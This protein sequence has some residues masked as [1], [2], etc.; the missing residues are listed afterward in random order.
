MKLL[1]ND[2]EIELD[3]GATVETILEHLGYKPSRSAVWVNGRK[4]LLA[5][6]ATWELRSNDSVKALRLF[7]GG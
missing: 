6:Y 7:S 4:L 1:L 5:E 3:Q 2:K